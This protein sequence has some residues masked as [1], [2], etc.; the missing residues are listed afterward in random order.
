MAIM[1]NSRSNVYENIFF[2]VSQPPDSSTILQPAGIAGAICRPCR[3]IESSRSI[4]ATLQRVM[5][6]PLHVAD[7][8]T[9]PP[10]GSL[11]AKVR[12]ANRSLGNVVDNGSMKFHELD[13]L[14]RLFCFDSALVGTV[15]RSRE[16]DSHACRLG[17]EISAPALRRACRPAASRPR[18]GP[19]GDRR[20]TRAS[21]T[22]GPGRPRRRLV[23]G[24]AR[25]R[26]RTGNLGASRSVRS[27]R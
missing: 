23:R 16:P 15:S 1:L 17:A 21:G 20:P 18:P 12:R 10:H 3:F 6:T 7:R 9:I 5:A 13:R 24:V 25:V 4:L 2:S 8:R 26:G 14:R 27:S 22:D 11:M 19:T